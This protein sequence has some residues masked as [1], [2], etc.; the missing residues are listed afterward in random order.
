MRTSSSVTSRISR[1]VLAILAV[2]NVAA[3]A[4]GSNP[5]KDLAT[6]LGAGPKNA[7]TPDFVAASRPQSL[8]YMPV[9]TRGTGRTT[10]ARTPD[11][12]K[13]AEA[14]LDAI[15]TQNEAAGAAAA[16]LGGTPPPQP[17]TVPAKRT[18]PNRTP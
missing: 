8:D 15:R 10:A 4:D 11:E 5:A 3:C 9:G 16:Q 18:N 2:A 6:T 12:I 7:P 1:M 17:V 14:E 13:A